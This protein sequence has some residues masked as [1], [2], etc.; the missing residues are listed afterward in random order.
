MKSTSLARFFPRLQDIFFVALFA[1]ALSLG[2]R[3][4]NLDGDLPRHL[5]MGRYILQNRIIPTTE[6]FIYPYLHQSYVPH[7]WLTNVLFYA[8]Y[9][10]TGLAGIVLLSALLLA[11]PFYLLYSHLSEKFQLRLPVLL[12]VAW[13]AAATSL[14]WAA[15]PHLVSMCLL[16]IWLI[17][18]DDLRSGKEIRI[19]R[20]PLLMLFWSNLHGEFIAGILVLF[21]Y[22]VGWIVDWFL[23]RS[24]ADSQVGRHLWLA[25]LASAAISLINPSGIGPWASMLGFVNNQYLMSR[26]VEANAPDFQTPEMRVLLALLVFSIF[27]LAIKRERISAGQGLLLAGF[28]AMS[29]MAVRNIHLYG[30]VAPFVLAGTLSELKNFRIVNRIESTLQNM[31][32]KTSGLAW[33]VI[34]VLVFGSSALFSHTAQQMY[35]F[36]GSAFPVEAVRWLESHP[37]QGRMLNN[38]NWGGYLELYL[39]PAQMPFIDS[40]SDTTGQVTRQYEDMVNVQGTWQDL[41]EQYEIT[42]VILPPDWP[43]ARELAVRGWEAV[44]QDQT[45]IILVRK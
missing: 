22:S 15:R 36:Q 14:N 3:M 4:L 33:V 32:A 43:L 9:S 44:Y 45:A 38:L 12:L 30:V 42:W 25:F 10:F 29:L 23:D 26:M 7:E 31:E 18:A 5:V 37:Q 24:H 16:A 41:L 6:L 28:S 19:W 34:S 8:V 39:W 21:A 40:M 17:W 27:L 20:F 1:A 35:Q 13:G 2:Q 11:I